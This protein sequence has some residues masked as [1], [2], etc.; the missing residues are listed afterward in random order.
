MPYF[1]HV[2]K[3]A[4]FACLIAFIGLISYITHPSQ[5][6]VENAAQI[7][8]KPETKHAG[9]GL[10]ENDASST[11]ENKDE[12]KSSLSIAFQDWTERYLEATAEEK[13]RLI[14]Q[15]VLLA[16]KRRALLAKLII[17]DPETAIA[18]ALPR[19]IRSQMPAEIVAEFEEIVSAR[20]PLS[21]HYTCLHPEGKVHDHSDD[22]FRT[23]VIGGKEYR[24]HVYGTRLR[25][26]SLPE[27]SLHGIALDGHLAVSDLRVRLL[28]AGEYE[29][30]D[31][32]P[33][34][35][36]PLAVEVDGK[37]TMLSS[38]DDLGAFN[39]ALLATE[40][41]PAI[42]AY[43]FGQALG[44]GLPKPSQAWTHGTKKL[45]VIR[46]DFS[47]LPGV[48]KNLD[49]S[50]VQENYVNSVING[51]SGVR[52][53]FQNN[54]FGKTDIL[55]APT[56][57]GDS[58]DITQVLRM[59]STASNYAVT[60]NTAILYIDARAAATA[61]GY[62]LN[63]YG[64]VV[65]A[66]S[67]LGD[68]TGSRMNYGGLAELMGVNSHINGQFDIGTLNHELGHNYGLAHANLWKV[69][70]GNPIS[71]NGTVEEYGDPFDTMG[72]D[73]AFS[74]HFGALMKARLHWLTDNSINY[75]GSSGTYRVYR[76][77]SAT[78]NLAL[79][80][81]L[82]IFRD[83]TWNYWI[84]YRRETSYA[85][86]D[87][88]A[89][90]IKGEDEDQR[91]A[92][93][94]LKTPGLNVYDS[95][96]ALNRTFIDPVAGVTIKPIGQGGSGADEWLD[97]EVTIQNPK[98]PRIAWISSSVRLD[99][100]VGNAVVT[101]S[102]KDNSNG[103]ISVN[104]ATVPGTALP[105][106]DFVSSSGTLTWASGDMV[107]KVI[108]IPIVAD[109]LGEGREFFTVSLSSPIGCIIDPQSSATVTIT[110]TD[111]R[112]SSFA[113]ASINGSVTRAIVT[114]GG[115][116]VIVGEFTELVGSNNITYNYS[117]IAQ[118]NPDGSVDTAFN[119]GTGANNTVHAVARQP[120]G[121]I[122]IGGS[123]SSFNGVP[124][125]NIARLNVD[126]SLDTTFNP[127]SGANGG[128]YAIVIQPNGK[129]LIGGGFTS[130]NGTSREYLARLNPSGNLDTTFTGPDFGGTSNFAVKSLALQADARLLVGGS[131]F[132][133]E[134]FLKGGICRVIST[135]AIDSSFSGVTNGAHVAG[136]PNYIRTVEE[137]AVQPNGQIIIGGDFTAFNLYTRERVARLNADGTLDM[138]FDP[139][140][141]SNCSALLVLPDESILIGGNFSTVS[142]SPATR[143]VRLTKN[144]F[145][146]STFNSSVGHTANVD[147][148]TLQSDGKVILAG[149]NGTFQGAS[150]DRPLWRFI[151]GMLDTPGVLQ[152]SNNNVRG[153][154]GASVSLNVTRSGG[155]LG[156]LTVGYST[157]PSAGSATQGLDYTSTGGTLTWLD[158]ETATKTILV[159]VLSDSISDTPENFT[160]NLGSP[161]IGG[162]ILAD[163]QQSIVSIDTAFE[164]WIFNR[165]TELER[166]N[167]SIS[168]PLADPEGDGLNN[169]TEFAL[170][171]N[172]KVPDSS[173]AWITSAQKINGINY[174]TLTFRR[175][176]PALDLA[177][178][179]QTSSELTP[180]SWEETAV[181]VGSAVL[182]GD[183]SETV[184][185]RDVLN[186]ESSAMRRF[187]RVKVTRTP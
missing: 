187:M 42:L 146:D 176:A 2:W 144:G 32:V 118:L 31:P 132:F 170:G 40:D 67:Y 130:Y 128:V 80:R 125:S 9:S 152:F 3:L 78:A 112:D 169:L 175:R 39:N 121:K 140:L 133:N 49:N 156:N 29:T 79:P 98:L 41:N 45:L 147:D 157:V 4:F 84:N 63:N 27:T 60:G 5:T 139:R 92:L 37:V 91:S 135:G 88:G 123:F 102:R 129:V 44:S 70:D 107:P 115:K 71:S 116:I 69:N 96:L 109:S 87:N 25:D 58:P 93:L 81:A 142:N 168:G 30:R 1:N 62:N 181:Q 162:A 14:P 151:P 61:F 171:L 52:K 124:R 64:L 103:S 83:P 68:L 22:F 104:Y 51:S 33:S 179:V 184:V 26:G 28:E 105:T 48:P 12:S 177:Y 85:L 6:K 36:V 77:D 23:S 57:A 19:M 174:L 95:P 100:K 76:F 7:V 134:S 108:S 172:P 165:F 21:M 110:D 122:L 47:D 173:N 149:G 97:I 182:H 113:A 94:D 154:E 66:T 155:A 131:F 137:I 101:V 126:G 163:R 53:F 65:V 75:I 138:D 54:S 56:V 74:H 55:M 185:F 13:I 153:I 166:A 143:I 114:P 8:P 86:A 17:A 159:P 150:P 180:N 10:V 16:Q 120:D 15:G 158:G 11:V 59:P 99:E 73:L 119:P 18:S 145:L 127:G 34:S 20:A 167:S 46:V 160:V 178:T 35:K 141:N 72:L 50:L 38:I 90:V 106:T 136:Y 183:G 164:S 82:R 111:S 43:D 24:A 117:G 186:I 148:L 161:L 89:I